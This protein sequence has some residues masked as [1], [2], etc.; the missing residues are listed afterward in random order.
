MRIAVL[1]AFPFPYPQG[2]QIYVAEQLRA[3]AARGAR[4]LLLCYGAGQGE[5]SPEL[6]VERG[7]GWATPHAMRSGPHPRKP[8]ADAALLAAYIAAHRRERFAIALAHN[9]EAAL[10]ALAA[11]PAIGVPV[12]YVAHT[13]LRRELSAY[14]RPAL[15]P[16][17]D[18][19]GAL[20]DHLIAARADGVIALS[21]AAESLFRRIAR[22]PVRRIPPS[23]APMPAPHKRLRAATAR[24]F[25][26]REG[27]FILYA[28]NL[29]AYQ[30]L[31]LL[32][33]AAAAR[34]DDAW[35]VAVATHDARPVEIAEPPLRRVVVDGF[36]EM[37]ALTHAAGFAVLARRRPGGFPVKL[38][39]YMEAGL[40]VVAPQ[41]V[42]D[43]LVDGESALLLPD[44]AP[45]RAW[46]AA[47]ERLERDA[48]LR[49]RLGEAARKHLEQEHGPDARAA[50]TLAFLAAVRDGSRAR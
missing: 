25:G 17:L 1:G 21:R 40:A 6:A 46:A 14:A 24:R 35:P 2:S 50:E 48:A 27:H 18:R 19:G 38:L 22:G 45:A 16:L 23:L 30:D 37:R 34:R 11:R 3:L 31:P 20:L 12:V 28:G 15:G 42:A 44:P 9:A 36:D 4:P 5:A 26:L 47:L 8:L 43:G 33:R 32:A 13:L 7:P 10:V 49:A 39:N 29:D 41:S